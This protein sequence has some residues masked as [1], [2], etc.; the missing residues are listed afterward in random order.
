MA[1]KHT[2]LVLSHCALRTYQ[3]LQQVD[4]VLSHWQVDPAPL[5]ERI[6]C[7]HQPYPTP[8]H[9][10]TLPASMPWGFLLSASVTPDLRP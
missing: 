5:P 7:F 6:L 4:L 2:S 9:T 10:H 8:T 1:A 3:L